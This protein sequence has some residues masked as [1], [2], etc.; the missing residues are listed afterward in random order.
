ML[1]NPR[2]KAKLKGGGQTKH[3]GGGQILPPE[4][5]PDCIYVCVL[6]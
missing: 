5:N 4:R 2:G 3:K 6:G 1:K